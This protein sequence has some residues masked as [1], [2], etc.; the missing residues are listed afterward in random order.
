LLPKH[1]RA[2]DDRVAELIRQDKI[3]ILIDLSLHLSGNRLLVL[4]RKPAPVQEFRRIPRQHRFADIDYRITDPYLDP[5]MAEDA[6]PFERPLRLPSFWCYDESAMTAGMD[7]I[8]QISPLP[9]ESVGHITFGCLNNFC[10]VNDRVLQLWARVLRA[11]PESHLLLLAPAGLTRRRTANRFA[12][13][14]VATD[15][16]EF[17]GHRRAR[18]ISSY[19]TGSTWDSTLSPT[20]DTPPASIPFGWAFR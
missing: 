19:I 1:R 7:E 5:P 18:I 16:I 8:P 11:V 4:A 17:V 20:T 9:A 3:D 14:G 13:L 2:G 10:K 6:P 15:R 12:Q